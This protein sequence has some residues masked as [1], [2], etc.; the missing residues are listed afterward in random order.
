MVQHN[1][2]EMEPAKKKKRQRMHDVPFHHHNQK[3]QTDINLQLTGCNQ[4]VEE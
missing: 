4:H 1:G 3:P 2:V